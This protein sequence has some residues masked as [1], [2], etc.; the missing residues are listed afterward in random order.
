M[1]CKK[2]AGFGCQIPPQIDHVKIY[3]DQQ[4][5]PQEA[6]KFY[7]RHERSKWKTEIGNPV[8]N[9]KTEAAKWIWE[10]KLHNPHLRIK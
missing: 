5:L 4:E 8:R 6:E 7:S 10:I 9:W 2:V 1:T 3:F